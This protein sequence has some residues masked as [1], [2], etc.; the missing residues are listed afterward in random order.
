MGS[1]LIFQIKY[2]REKKS[3]FKTAFKCSKISLTL[4]ITGF[5]CK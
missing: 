4:E 2:M 3:A 1:F 5:F